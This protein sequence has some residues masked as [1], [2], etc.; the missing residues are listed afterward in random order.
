MH[1]PWGR[2]YQH[3][4]TRA[5]QLTANAFHQD[6]LHST[7][8]GGYQRFNASAF[9]GSSITAIQRSSVSVS[10]QSKPPS[11]LRQTASPSEFADQRSFYSTATSISHT[12][13][14]LG[15]RCPQF[16]SMVTQTFTT[17]ASS[18][19]LSSAFT[20]TSKILQLALGTINLVVYHGLIT[21]DS[22]N[23]LSPQNE[24][25]TQGQLNCY[26]VHVGHYHL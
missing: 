12:A 5:D 4:H 21:H 26:L 9:Q 11:L 22:Y 19:Q 23:I 17:R 24:P 1:S 20:S 25:I 6:S 13:T 14:W 15:R 8:G 7:G 16:S 2:G 3:S 18:V 10:Q